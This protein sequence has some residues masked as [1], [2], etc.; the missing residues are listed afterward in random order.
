MYERLIWCVPIVVFGAGVVRPRAALIALAALLPLFGVPPGGP[1]LAALDVAAIAAIA[2]AWRAPRE[3]PAAS[4]IDFAVA[5]WAAVAAASLVPVVYHP[6][7]WHPRSL[8]ALAQ[9]LPA[10]P[11]WSILQTWRVLLDVLLGCGLYA[12]TRRAFAGRSARPLAAALGAGLGLVLVLGLAEHAGLLDLGGYRPI[13][14][15]IHDTRLH[16]VFFHAAFLAEYVTIAAP[17]VIA[18]LISSS[19]RALRAAAYALGGLALVALLFTEQR[20]AWF[21]ALA[22]LG[23]AA[24][25]LGPSLVRDRARIRRLAITGATAVAFT[26]T[27]VSLRPAVLEPVKTRLGEATANLSNRP[28]LWSAAAEMWRQRPILGWGAGSFAPAYDH[29]FPPDD[30]PLAVT[31]TAHNTALTVLAECGGLGL[32]TLLLLLA[33]A[34]AAI[35]GA[36]RR[37]GPDRALDFGR[38]LALAAIVVYGLVQHMWY[39]RNVSWL[40]WLLLGVFPATGPRVTKTCRTVGLALVAAAALALPWRLAALDPWPAAGDRSFGFNEIEKSGGRP[41]QWTSGHAERRLAWSAPV[42]VLELANGHP[43]GVERPVHV[44]V[45]F[46]GRDLGEVVVRG[47]WQQHRFLVGPPERPQAVLEL[48]VTPT[49]RPFS[50]YRRRDLAPSRDMRRLG[51]AMRPP[52]FEAER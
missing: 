34:V 2:L 24:V 33:G 16:S 19:S 43:L 45:R 5:A 37:D 1:Y 31:S 23:L 8:L 50:D 28:L 38:A 3:K 9:H 41:L 44:E 47:G 22:Q 36:R 4:G 26:A 15:A 32:S 25:L 17:F 18:A 42:L 46:A 13:V 35:A 49:F 48:Q 40:I 14:W 27:A 52:R 11:G 29:L 21:T 10:V 39:L 20:G 30:P 12:A 6:P 51:V 7:S